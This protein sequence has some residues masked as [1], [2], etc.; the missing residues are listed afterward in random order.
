MNT[1]DPVL[2]EAFTVLGPM[3]AILGVVYGL[4]LLVS[5]VGYILRGLAILNMSRARG[6]ENGW[7]GFIPL[8]R[9]WQLGKI[10]H[11]IEI[12]DKKITNPELWLVIAPLVY[13]ITFIIGY[14]ALMV[15]YFISIVSLAENAT[16]EAIVGPMTSLFIG[17]FVFVLVILAA[18]VFWFLFLYLS[19]HK[20]FSQYAS[21]QKPV[22]YLILS[23]FIPL[24]APII[25]YMLS[26]R[27]LLPSAS[28]EFASLQ[29]PSPAYAPPIYATQSAQE[30][31]SGE[32]TV[33]PTDA[34]IDETDVLSAEEAAQYK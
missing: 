15:P 20:V 7:L 28:A 19:L 29:N 34:V 26:K 32:T 33:I 27:P 24:A 31:P 12:G 5:I 4:I 23:M 6:L 22:F 11:E 8:A 25:L 10:A 21:G 9:N 16:P 30:A 13:W 3:F 17:L 18:E 2:A 1:A 14:T